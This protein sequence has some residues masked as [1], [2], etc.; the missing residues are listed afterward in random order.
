[1]SPQADICQQNYD[2]DPAH[3][4]F[5]LNVS[6]LNDLY[7]SLGDLYQSLHIDRAKIRSAREILAQMGD[8]PAEYSPVA[9]LAVYRKEEHGEKLRKMGHTPVRLHLSDASVIRSF[10]IDCDSC[11]C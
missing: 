3:W 2:V 8:V 7:Q 1:M 5:R 10:I 11:G 6:V 4:Y 9:M